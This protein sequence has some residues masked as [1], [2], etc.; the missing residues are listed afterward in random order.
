[1]I[2]ETWK[3]FPRQIVQKINGLL[4]DAEPNPVK[5]FQLYKMCQFEN[6][7]QESFEN[8]SDHLS[9][10]FKVAKAE[11]SKSDFDRYLDRPMD[12]VSYEKFHLTFH[13]AAINSS[14][15]RDIAS[16]A[17]HM[18]RLHFKSDLAIFSV[19]ALYETVYELTH[20]SFAEKDHDIEF[21]DFCVS[22]QQAGF[23]L[24]GKRYENFQIQILSDLRKLHKEQTSSFERKNQIRS[25]IY[26]TQTEIIWLESVEK[27]AAR[28]EKLPRYPLSKGPEKD[29]LIEILRCTA[30][31]EIAFSSDLQSLMGHRDAIQATVLNRCRWLL[32]NRKG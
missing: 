17:H 29:P 22:W 18:L 28:S 2:Q 4:D 14:S 5:A 30:L 16:W 20:P 23:K 12:F 7:W 8:F 3:S 32:E 10:F 6:L 21:E 25:G 9:D 27:A 26:L 31:Y 19:E 15:L 13:S 11:R 1:M 24:Y